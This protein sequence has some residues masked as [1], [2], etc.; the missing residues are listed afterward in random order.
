MRNFPKTLTM[1]ERA[2]GGEG[3]PK[4][5]LIT[6]EYAG[7][8]EGLLVNKEL[9]YAST[10]ITNSEELV[11]GTLDDQKQRLLDQMGALRYEPIHKMKD[12][13]PQKYKL[14][15]KVGSTSDDI[16]VALMMCLYWKH[17]FWR[18]DRLEYIQFI[19]MYVA[20]YG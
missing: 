10:C 6:K 11:H 1:C 9:R 17:E 15:A 8:I 4:T 19:R 18:S 5:E 20:D 2:G 16:L 3:V 12:Y 7:Q 14:T 13:E